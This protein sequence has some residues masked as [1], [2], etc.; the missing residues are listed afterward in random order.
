MAA[1]KEIFIRYKYLRPT[2][3]KKQKK[4]P[5]LERKLRPAQ[6]GGERGI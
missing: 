1:V 6:P 3:P 4:K 5:S 2:Q